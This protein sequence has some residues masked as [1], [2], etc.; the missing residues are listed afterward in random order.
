MQI[1]GAVT[2]EKKIVEKSAEIDGAIDVILSPPSHHLSLFSTFNIPFH[3][4][5]LSLS[6][7]L[8]LRPDRP[9]VRRTNC[10]NGRPLLKRKKS[11]ESSPSQTAHTSNETSQTKVSP[12]ITHGRREGKEERVDVRTEGGGTG[13]R[14]ARCVHES[15]LSMR[16][17]G[18]RTDQSWDRETRVGD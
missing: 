1:N 11:E 5:S 13:S 12:S 7:S 10:Y 8:S 3:A 6:L 16:C 15:L 17:S 14:E 2:P 4:L 9:F 18:E